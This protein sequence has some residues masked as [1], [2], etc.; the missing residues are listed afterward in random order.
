MAASFGY[1]ASVRSFVTNRDLPLFLQ[2]VA[3]DITES[4]TAEATLQRMHLNL[5]GEVRQRTSELASIN[6]TLRA[7]IET[8]KELEEK[9]RQRAQQL[10]DESKRKD[11][12][13]AMLAHELRNP[14]SP[15]LMAVDLLGHD[16]VEEQERSWALA[17]IGRQVK[18]MTR[19]IDD[20]LDIWAPSARGK[21]YCDA[22]RWI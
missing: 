16:N 21:S 14:L 1:T 11:Q 6:E 7:E 12:F 2:G 10:A 4:K 15:V 5:E 20:L 22:G 17:M 3:Y 18:H 9:L 8:R 13:L 19:L